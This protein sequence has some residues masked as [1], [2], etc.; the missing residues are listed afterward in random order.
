MHNAL[1]ASALLDQMV[2]PGGLINLKHGARKLARHLSR[3]KGV[4]VMDR[5]VHIGFARQGWMV[6]NQYWTPG[7]LSPMA[8]MGKYYMVYGK[9]FIPPR[10][11][12]RQ[13]AQRMIME[14]MMDNLG[15]CRFHRAWAEE[16]MPDVVEELYGLKDKFIQN[17]KH[18]ATRI[19]SRNASVFWESERT[20][21]FLYRFLRKKVDE[22]NVRDNELDRWIKAFEEDKFE[23]GLQFWF[24]IHKGIHESLR[25]FH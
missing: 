23:A 16:I 21:D 17:L 11:L 24:E 5:F 4:G 14:L 8:I 7:V 19:N 10:E 13:N 18:T 6:P 22:D 15:F 9:D 1:I 20:V 25:E 2:K 3:D 12:G